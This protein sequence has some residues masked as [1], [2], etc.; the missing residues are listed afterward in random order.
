MLSK[1]QREKR[2]EWTVTNA[3]HMVTAH[4]KKPAIGVDD[5]AK[6]VKMVERV[7][8]HADAQELKYTVEKHDHGGVHIHFGEDCYV[9]VFPAD[10]LVPPSQR[11][12]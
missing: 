11:P 12:N 2:D 7:R 5:D 3:L 8:R 4:G 9:Y 10:R 1:K 6:V